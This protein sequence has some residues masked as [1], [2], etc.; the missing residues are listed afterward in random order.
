MHQRILTYYALGDP[1]RTTV[2]FNIL[3]IKVLPTAAIL[4]PSGMLLGQ[5]H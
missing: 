3:G 5:T 1:F 4:V 2:L